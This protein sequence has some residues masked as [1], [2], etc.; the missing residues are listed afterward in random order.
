MRQMKCNLAP[1]C[2]IEYWGEKVEEIVAWE[3]QRIDSWTECP[4]IDAIRDGELAALVDSL[5]FVLAVGQEGCP[6][7]ITALPAS[8][9]SVVLLIAVGIPDDQCTAAKA[10]RKRDLDGSNSAIVTHRGKLGYHAGASVNDL[11]FVAHRSEV[12]AIG[13]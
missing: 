10:D 6:L 1:S 12:V 13:E 11:E 4:W 7:N 8:A 9:A 5:H 3:D 2:R